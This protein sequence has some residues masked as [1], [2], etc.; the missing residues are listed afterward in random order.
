MGQPCALRPLPSCLPS[1]ASPAPCATCCSAGGQTH[2]HTNHP[3]V[4]R[5]TAQN[6]SRCKKKKKKLPSPK[7]NLIVRPETKRK[8][9]PLLPPKNER[10]AE[11]LTGN[12]TVIRS[13]R[14][15]ITHKASASEREQ[16]EIWPHFCLLI[17]RLIHRCSNHCNCH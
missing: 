15:L 10:V 16:R 9:P 2:T 1:P 12:K 6:K 11:M 4:K 8:L 3:V 17:M 7:T 13:Y 14:F 5:E